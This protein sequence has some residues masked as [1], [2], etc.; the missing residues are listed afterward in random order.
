MKLDV[1]TLHVAICCALFFMGSVLLLM[2]RVHPTEKALTIWAIGN[3]LS[4]AG[5]ALFGIPSYT[6]Y[7]PA[8][9]L[10]NFLIV[11]GALAHWLGIRTFFGWRQLWKPLFLFVAVYSAAI[12]VFTLWM[13]QLWIRLLITSLC[14]GGISILSV[15]NL[16]KAAGKNRPLVVN[17]LVWV[18]IIHALTFVGRAAF[19]SIAR[20][21][22]GY[23]MLHANYSSLAVLESMLTAFAVNICYLLLVSDRLQRALNRLAT[24]DELTGLL[25]RRAFKESTEMELSRAQRREESTALLMMDLDNFKSINDRYGHNGGD[26]IL[27][28]FSKILQRMTRAGDITA[29]LGGEEF[30]ALLPSSNTEDAHYV[31][32]RIRLLMQQTQVKTDQGLAR[33]TVSIGLTMIRPGDSIEAGFRRADRALYAAKRAGRNCVYIELAQ[34]KDDE[35]SRFDLEWAATEGKFR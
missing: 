33:T 26:R 28:R 6:L 22:S 34:Q 19:A 27:Q 35:P 11:C 30:C 1:V 32:E 7:S 29:R 8:I 16:Q 25:N 23:A 18:S 31:A 4:G 9:F 15:V 5:T 2:R 20:P 21:V 13:P 12:L 14:I 10:S 3:L 24:T 17:F